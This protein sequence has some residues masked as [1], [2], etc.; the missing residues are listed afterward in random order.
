MKN[1]FLLALVFCLAA[2]LGL[3]GCDGISFMTDKSKNDQDSL[4]TVIP[5]DDPQLA[6]LILKPQQ[7]P[8]KVSRDPF[9][10]IYEWNDKRVEA[11]IV[12]PV[13]QRFDDLTYIGMMKMDTQSIALLKTKDKKVMLKMNEQFRGYI[14]TEISNT[15]IVLSDGVAKITLKRGTKK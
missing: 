1:N 3:S 14:V 13:K 15:Q 6:K 12:E 10:P 7:R 4:L 9:K 2:I 11:K 8:V 5:V